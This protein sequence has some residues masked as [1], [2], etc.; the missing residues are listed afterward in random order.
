[1]RFFVTRFAATETTWREGPCYALGAQEALATQEA[2]GCAEVL[3][4]VQGDSE[5]RPLRQELHLKDFIA[6]R[7][8]YI[9]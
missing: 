6:I 2:L 7:L 1:M 4:G 3:A 5:A 9:Y 8:I